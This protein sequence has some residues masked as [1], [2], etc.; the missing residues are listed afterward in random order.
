MAKYLLQIVDWTKT[1]LERKET[2]S[3]FWI[4]KDD[5]DLFSRI[6][7]QIYYQPDVFVWLSDV[8][9]SILRLEQIEMV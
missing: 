7:P 6:D 8:I 1:K 5:P 3:S 9:I 2:F 4:D